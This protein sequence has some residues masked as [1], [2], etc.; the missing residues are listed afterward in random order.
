MKN[1]Q[2]DQQAVIIALSHAQDRGPITKI[3]NVQYEGRYDGILVDYADGTSLRIAACED[4]EHQ[5]GYLSVVTDM[6]IT[7]PPN[8][9]TKK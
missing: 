5:W 9:D 8:I 4:D 3:R 7:Y 6:R 1:I 2:N